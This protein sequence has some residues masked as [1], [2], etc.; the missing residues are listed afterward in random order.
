ME[1]GDQIVPMDKT[2]GLT[3]AYSTNGPVLLRAAQ[4]IRVK[5]GTVP[6][7]ESL[8]NP[9]QMKCVGI[10]VHDVAHCHGGLQCMVIPVVDEPDVIIPFTYSEGNH[11]TLNELPTEQDKNNL[12]VYDILEQRGGIQLN[13]PLSILTSL[14]MMRP[15]HSAGTP[16]GVNLTR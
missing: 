10:K 8:I 1:L 14:L 6:P 2:Q 15:F 12:P 5:Q 4:S 9:D 11:L 3:K 16:L 13:N 7:I